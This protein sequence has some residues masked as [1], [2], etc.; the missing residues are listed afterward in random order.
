MSGARLLKTAMN[1]IR[2]AISGLMNAHGGVVQKFTCVA[3]SGFLRQFAFFIVNGYFALCLSK[4]MFGTLT[5]AFGAL[6]VFIGVADFGLREIAWRDVARNPSRTADVVNTVLAARLAMTLVAMFGFIATATVYCHGKQDWVIF[7]IYSLGSFFNMTSFDY[8]FLG[9]D[10]MGTI[11][12]STAVAYAYYVPACFLSV[13]SDSTAWLAALHFVI[14]HMIFFGL[15]YRE[16]RRN[17][18]PTR[19]TFRWDTTS[20]FFR[21]SWPLGINGLVFRLT[22]NYPVLLLGLILSS[23]AVSEYR[24]AEM[25]YSLFASLGLYLGSSMYTTYAVYEGESDGR[26]AHSVEAAL[27]TIFL[28]HVPIAF[29]FVTLLPLL[30]K[31]FMHVGSAGEEI[32]CLLLGISLPLGVATRYL[33]T[34]L[35]S[36]GLNTQLLTV[37]LACVVVGIGMGIG[38]VHTAGAPGI[39]A[40]VLCTELCGLALI[41]MVIKRKLPAL[42]FAPIVQAPL[43]TAAVLLGVQSILWSTGMPVL[44]QGFFPMAIGIPLAGWLIVSY[45]R[46]ESVADSAQILTMPQQSNTAED[47]IKTLS[48]RQSA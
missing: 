32:L 35:P 16:Y 47:I 24:L 27:R 6:L 29:G 26:I 15:L 42:R 41:L 23:V 34:C 43:A 33:K 20:D 8:P 36:I 19:L 11:S 37:N 18:G 2:G 9:R 30:L 25:F 40:S 38:L 13:H 31:R 7:L 48:L 12:K 1:N 14:A 21:R 22:I 45:I 17:F 44:F 4:E 46:A 5:C 39:A 28:A 10:K 3:F